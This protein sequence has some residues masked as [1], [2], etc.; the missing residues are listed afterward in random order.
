[1]DNKDI[2]ILLTS[3]YRT[4]DTPDADISNQENQQPN[5][6]QHNFEIFSWNDANTK[7]FLSLYKKKKELIGSRRIKNFKEM[8]K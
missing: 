1:V 4:I 5:V 7:L 3:T 6:T 8:W 2:L